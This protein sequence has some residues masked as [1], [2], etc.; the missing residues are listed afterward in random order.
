MSGFIKHINSKRGDVCLSS[1]DHLENR[2]LSGT[3]AEVMALSLLKWILFSRV[4]MLL[5]LLLFYLL[6]SPKSDSVLPFHLASN[7]KTDSAVQEANVAAKWYFCEGYAFDSFLKHCGIV[8]TRE[9]LY[10]DS[11]QKHRRPVMCK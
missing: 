4:W 3:Q 7:Q 6:L 8:R 10:Q 1:E 2:L 9:K 11:R 5:L